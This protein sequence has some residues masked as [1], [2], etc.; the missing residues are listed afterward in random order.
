MSAQLLRKRHHTEVAAEPGE[1]SNEALVRQKVADGEGRT[2]FKDYRALLER[3]SNSSDHIVDL[4]SSLVQTEAAAFELDSTAVSE[5]DF[6]ELRS[7]Q[8]EL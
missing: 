7:K 4:L 5:S 1:E 8:N 3:L 2:V 6:V